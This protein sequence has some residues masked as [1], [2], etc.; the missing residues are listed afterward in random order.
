MAGRALLFL[1]TLFASFLL[2]EAGLRLTGFDYPQ[3][4]ERDDIVGL[5]L[6]PNAE[7][8]FTEEGRA[9]VKVNSAGMRDI[10]RPREKPASRLR[11]AVVG[12]SYTEAIQ[13]ARE[14]AFPARLE[15]HLNTCATGVEVLNFGV[16][17][18]GTAQ[19]L[20]TLRSKVWDYAPDIVLLA[21]FPSN[22]VMNNSRDLEPDRLRPF[23]VA[24]DGVLALDDSFRQQRSY[25]ILSSA[26]YRFLRQ[27]SHVL[28][29]ALKARKG[30]VAMT[31]KSGGS[32]LGL[33][34]DVFQ[35]PAS[36]EWERAWDVTERLLAE[37]QQ[38][39]AS[40]GAKMAIASI[41]EAAAVHPDK[42]LR[43][44]YVAQLGARDFQY[45]ERRLAAFAKKSGVAF[46]P[47]TDGM[48]E[49]GGGKA[50]HGFGA[51]LGSGHWN[52][53]GHRTAATLMGEFLCALP[54]LKER[55][56]GPPL[57]LG[58]AKP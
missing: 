3:F 20:L 22:D 17:G 26:P 12:D 33:D 6:R 47:L 15:K 5:K 52:E 57:Q 36:P 19:Q 14:D 34:W 21:F 56:P 30:W 7:G 51:S 49:R 29:L 39:V 11:I 38:E 27:H 37:M 1:A 4:H 10:E 46:L 28:E 8:W 50:L 24:Q 9:Y 32:E 35:P 58:D 54:E 48:N 44:R 23:F 53:D 25:R 43:E 42:A 13:V 16:S 41:T 2:A 45:A 55:A 18:F 31:A 40:H